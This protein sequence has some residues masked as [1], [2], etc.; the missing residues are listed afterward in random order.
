MKDSIMSDDSDSSKIL[1]C[2][3]GGIVGEE[4]GDGCFAHPILHNFAAR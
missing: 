3:A 4:K 2:V 1:A